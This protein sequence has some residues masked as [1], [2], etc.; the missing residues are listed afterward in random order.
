[1]PLALANGKGSVRLP[2][3]AEQFGAKARSIKRFEPSAKADGNLNDY[4]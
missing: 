1:L 2:A 3:L 4:F